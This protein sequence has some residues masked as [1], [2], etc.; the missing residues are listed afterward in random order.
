[1]YTYVSELIKGRWS[2]GDDR[3]RTPGPESELGQHCDG[4]DFERGADTQQQ[5]SL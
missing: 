1:M 5:L 2:L 3:Q 4:M